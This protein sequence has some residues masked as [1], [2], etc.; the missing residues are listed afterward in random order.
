MDIIVQWAEQLRTTMLTLSS[1]AAVI[2]V[3]GVAIMYVLSPLP[4]LKSWKEN[5]PKAMDN[6]V[7][8]LIILA[9]V[10]SGG[11]AMLLPGG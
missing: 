10:G 1:I 5:N 3:L 9:L 8:G 7:I 4:V 2:G 11:I 6:V